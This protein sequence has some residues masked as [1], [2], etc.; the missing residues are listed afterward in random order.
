MM[1]TIIPQQ[2]IAT[3]QPAST[4]TPCPSLPAIKTVSGTLTAELQALRLI[5]L[6]ESLMPANQVNNKHNGLATYEGI[7][8]SLQ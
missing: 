8:K 3:P 2:H 4:T 1:L 5:D 7:L 6:A